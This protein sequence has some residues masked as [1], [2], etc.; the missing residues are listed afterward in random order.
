MKF[1]DKTIGLKKMPNYILIL[2]SILIAVGMWYYVRVGQQMETQ[3]DVNL[4]FSGIPQDLVITSGLINKMHVRLRGPSVLIRS[5]PPEMLNYVINLSKIKRGNNIIPLGG[6]ELLAIY[7]AFEV[8]DIDPPKMEIIAER[9]T[10]RSVPI[11]YIYDTPAGMN[12][13]PDN[14]Q[15]NESVVTVRGPESTIANMRDLPLVIHL[16]PQAS[17]KPV[18]ETKILATPNFVTAIPPSVKISYKLPG[19][20]EVIPRVCPVQLIGKDAKDYTV[21]PPEFSLFVELPKNLTNNEKYLKKMRLT[22][23]I[24]DLEP[25]EHKEIKVNVELPDGMSLT[26]PF[27]KDVTVTRVR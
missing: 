13:T 3:L 5:I 26:T 1:Y 22:V 11:R 7:R 14:F 4:D 20:R 17:D 24:P 16:D 10:E 12:I 25:L 2:F 23:P 27:N 21:E 18:E 8:I 6:E 19:T 9:L 15:I